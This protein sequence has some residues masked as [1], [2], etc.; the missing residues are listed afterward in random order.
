M[1]CCL[2]T[3]QNLFRRISKEGSKN[4]QTNKQTKQLDQSKK[5][6]D[7]EIK[8]KIDQIMESSKP[9]DKTFIELVKD[10]KHHI[11]NH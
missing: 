11:I 3:I 7:K 4:K 1:W 6:L 8:G 5:I 9:L 2:A 10:A